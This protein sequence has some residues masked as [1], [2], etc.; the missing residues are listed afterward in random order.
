MSATLKAFA[1]KLRNL[2]KVVAIRVATAA[3][4]AVTDA[5]VE[6]FRAGEDAHGQLWVPKEDGSRATLVDSGA[7]Q[8]RLGYTA[9]GTKLRCQ[10]GVSYAKYQIGRRPVFPKQGEPLPKAYVAALDSAAKSVIDAELTS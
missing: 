9:I 1:E 6:T 3:A 5:S 2:P 8:S 4:P 7:L 10:L